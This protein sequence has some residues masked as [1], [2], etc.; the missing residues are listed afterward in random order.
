MK[1]KYILDDSID[2]IHL[3]CGA[4]LLNTA[5]TQPVDFI[6]AK[7]LDEIFNWIKEKDQ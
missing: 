6:H 3:Y 4:Y 7:T 5:D 1:Y 2:G